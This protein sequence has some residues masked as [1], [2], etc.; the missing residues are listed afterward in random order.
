MEMQVGRDHWVH[1]APSAQITKNCGFGAVIARVQILGL[2]GA[3]PRITTEAFIT[4]LILHE[5]HRT[6]GSLK[7]SPTLR[8][9]YHHPPAFLCLL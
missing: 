4:S 1:A 2:P 8:R 7:L 3:D 6:T 5:H 9:V